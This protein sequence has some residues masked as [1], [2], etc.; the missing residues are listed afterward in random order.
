ML[1]TSKK[2]SHTLSFPQFQRNRE[3]SNRTSPT[4]RKT[5]SL[6]ESNEVI[7]RALLLYIQTSNLLG[8]PASRTNIS[9]LKQAF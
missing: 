8:K 7:M 1:T 3:E 6:L 4:L 9:S 5:R 2:H